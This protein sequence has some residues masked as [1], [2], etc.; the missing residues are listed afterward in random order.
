V[1]SNR[2]FTRIG[3]FNFK[4]KLNRLFL[5]YRPNLKKEN[6]IMLDSTFLSTIGSTVRSPSLNSGQD[7]HSVQVISYIKKSGLSFPIPS[8]QSLQ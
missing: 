2:I 7:S 8:V 4:N 5:L 6:E 3:F 1:L